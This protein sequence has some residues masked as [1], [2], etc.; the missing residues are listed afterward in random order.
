VI[1]STTGHV[2]SRAMKPKGSKWVDE[3]FGPHGG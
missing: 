3:G 2:W 1:D